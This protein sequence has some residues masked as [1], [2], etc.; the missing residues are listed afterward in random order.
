MK[1][2]VKL[3]NLRNRFIISTGIFIFYCDCEENPDKFRSAAWQ[4]F[5]LNFL[6][7][8]L[9]RW[10]FMNIGF[11]RLLMIVFTGAVLFFNPAAAAKQ[12]DVFVITADEIKK[13]NL[14]K[15]SDVLNQIP[16]VNAGDSSISI[17]GSIKVKVMLNGRPIND[18]T[19]SHGFVKFDLVSI[20]NVEKIEI[21]RGTGAL[22][23]G[24]N[25]SGGVV[26]I[27]TKKIG[28]LHGNIK[29]FFGNFNTSD[30][31]FNCRTSKNKFGYSIS[32]GY[33]HTDGYQTNGDK[34]KKRCG[35]KFEYKVSKDLD[36]AFSGDF[37][38]DKRGLSGR[39]EYPTPHSRKKS[40]MTSLAANIKIKKISSETFYNDGKT[41]NKDISRNIDNSITVRKFGEDISTFVDTGKWGTFTYGGAFRF[42]QAESTKFNTKNENSIAMFAE[43][44]ITFNAVPVNFSFG[45]RGTIYSEFDN[46]INP[47]IKLSY[48]SS[49]LKNRTV[50]EKNGIV[51]DFKR[52]WTV[53]FSYNRINNTPSFY[54][55]YD[56]TSTK[57]PNP[58]LGTETADNFSLNFFMETT[59]KFS[60]GVS[61]FYNTIADR[62]VYEL[63][64]D[65]I[66]RYKNFGRVVY[67]GG[68]ITLNWAPLKYISLKANYIYL[69]AVDENTGL[70]MVAKPRHRIYADLTY[71]PTR[72]ISII[73]NL[74]YN[75]KQ[76]T[77]SD[78]TTYETQQFIEN[79]RFE[80]S[81]AVPIFRHGQME[82]FGVIKNLTNENYRYG[83]GWLAPP[84]TWILGLNYK[85]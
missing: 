2:K 34:E 56:I 59:D 57:K 29:S 68:D 81:P 5:S 62:I 43:N 24:D 7:P 84:R 18:P 72:Q 20:D 28:N 76:F 35:G 16:G 15:I 36:F 11:L 41:H 26:L 6:Q 70:W 38:T 74:K 75:S 65:G 71:A 78:N 61:L 69:K 17:R 49:S 50:S 64:D 46:A 21:C 79:L 58:N 44:N 66:G 13:M 82:I 52:K 73:A 45:I 39:P 55:R 33:E 10:D 25:A 8:H 63:G 22:K 40:D 53:S 37:I 12:S 80:Y 47:E 30:I 60:W 4:L 48:H 42:G 83:D 14:H 31:H 9:T 3:K 27:T 54:Q 85:F 19:S 23:Y 32:A 1:W 51:S 77:R 67:K